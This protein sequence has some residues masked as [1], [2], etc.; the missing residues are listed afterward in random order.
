MPRKLTRRDLAAALAASVPALASPRAVPAKAE[1]DELL[2]AARAQVLKNA[3]RLA[4]S[5]IPM[6]T[7]P[8]F[9]FKA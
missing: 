6:A 3:G 4:A 8:A 1:E 5:E 9:L 2:A 7:E